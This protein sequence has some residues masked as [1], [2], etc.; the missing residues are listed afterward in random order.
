MK[1]KAQIPTSLLRVGI[2]FI[3]TFIL[4]CLEPLSWIQSSRMF[5][6]KI[7]KQVVADG[8][9]RGSPA[10]SPKYCTKPASR[11]QAGTVLS[12]LTQ[13]EAK[14]HPTLALSLSY[15]VSWFH[16]HLPHFSWYHLNTTGRWNLYIAHKHS[17]MRNTLKTSQLSQ[18]QRTYSL[19]ARPRPPRCSGCWRPQESLLHAVIFLNQQPSAQNHQETPHHPELMTWPPSCGSCPGR[20]GKVF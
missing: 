13:H 12:P 14:S 16:P 8:R 15:S 5:Y 19:A 10:P 6:R 1:F 9:D 20:R 4:V 2:S 17:R 3:S 11:L 18:L 7:L